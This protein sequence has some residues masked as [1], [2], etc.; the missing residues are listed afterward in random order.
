ME[1]FVEFVKNLHCNRYDKFIARMLEEQVPIAVFSSFT[2]ENTIN[3]GYILLGTLFEAG[4][5]V[6]MFLTPRNPNMENFPQ[7]P[8][9][10]VENIMDFLEN[11][12]GLKY[13]FVHIDLMANG[14]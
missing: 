14:F 11:P 1:K 9:L 5:N 7:Y 8:D 3:N 6:K 10:K 2:S 13:V 4:F 12:K